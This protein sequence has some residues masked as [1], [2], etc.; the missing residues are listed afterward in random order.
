MKPLVSIREALEDP[1][2]LGTA[3]EGPTWHAWRSLLIA[4]MG[5]PLEDRPDGGLHSEKRIRQHRPFQGHHWPLE[6][7]EDG[8][9]K[10]PACLI[11]RQLNWAGQ[12]NERPDTLGSLPER[13]SAEPNQ[14]WSRT[15]RAGYD[16][17][18]LIAAPAL[19]AVRRRDL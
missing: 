12:L 7:Y 17:P 1:N 15:G 2:L 19:A 11:A 6:Y 14:P 10:L 8:Y 13:E 3:L 4:A 16:H 5:E 18:T 9:P